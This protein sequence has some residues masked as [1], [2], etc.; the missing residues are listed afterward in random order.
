MLPV[1]LLL[2]DLQFKAPFRAIGSE[3][4]SLSPGRSKTFVGSHRTYS[5]SI[6]Q[7]PTPCSRGKG[8]GKHEREQTKNERTFIDQ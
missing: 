4:G 2:S 5:V 1:R 6:V 8:K 3:K 7:S